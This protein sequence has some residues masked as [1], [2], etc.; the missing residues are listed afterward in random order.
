MKSETKLTSVK[1]LKEIYKNFRSE[2]IVQDFTLQKLVNRSIHKFLTYEE[3]NRE[4]K[5]YD[6]LIVSGSN[7]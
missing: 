2:S 5:Q 3:Y 7:F 6:A 1:L 4:I